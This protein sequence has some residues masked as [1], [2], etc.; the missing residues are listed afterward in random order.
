MRSRIA[1]I[2]LCV[3]FGVLSTDSLNGEVAG[4]EVSGGVVVCLGF[5]DGA[6]VAGLCSDDK[7]LVYGLHTEARRVAE[8]RSHIASRDL[9]GQVSAET[10]DG[11]NLPFGD[12]IVNLVIV[13]G[14]CAVSHEEL[15]RVLVAGGKVLCTGGSTSYTKPW[16]ADIDEWTHFLFDS[17]NNAVSRD[18]R[19]GKPRRVQWF[20]GPEHSRD[21]DALASMSAM[22]TSNGRVFYIYDEGPVSRIHQPPEWKLIARDAFN[23]KLLWKHDLPDWMTHLYFFRSGPLQL[24]RR[25]V[26]V[27]DE[28]FVTLGFETPVRKLDAATGATLLT[29][30]GSEETEELILHEDTLLVVKGDPGLL[31]EKSDDALGFFEIFENERGTVPK[32]IVAYHRES[33]KQLWTV[34]TDNLKSLVPLSLC[35]QGKKAFYL[36]DD[37]LHCLDLEKGTELWAS[38]FESKG[39]FIRAYAP[40]VVVHDDVIMCVSEP[41]IRTFS[42]EDG[43]TLWEHDKGSTGFGSPAD[44]FIHN[45]KAWTMAMQKGMCRKLGPL[46]PPKTVVA[47][48][49]HTGKI[50]KTLP[51]VVNQHHHRCYRN[52]ATETLIIIGYSGIQIFDYEKGTVDLNQW[53]RGICQYGFMPANGY[54]Y[55]PPDP[56]QCYGDVKVNGFFALSESNSLD[57]I[58]IKP[59]LE[60]G[61][62]YGQFQV[63]DFGVQA[64]GSWPTYRGNNTRTGGTDEELPEK[65]DRKWET[66]VGRTVT[67]PVIA[68]GKIYVADRDGYTVHCL[69]SGTGKKLWNFMANGPVDTPPTIVSGGPVHLCVFG[70][71]DGSVYC[72]N[73]KD[74]TLIWRFK[75]SGIERRIGS[76]DRLES[77]WRISGAV[78]VRDGNVYFAAGRSS[79]LDGGIKLYG[80]DLETGALRHFYNWESRQNDR[81]GALAGIFREKPGGISMRNASFDFGLSSVSGKTSGTGF[82]DASWFH[83]QRGATGAGQLNVQNSTGI[84]SALNPYTGLKRRRS[85]GSRARKDGKWNQI[86][87]LHQKYARYLEKEWF[88]AGTVLKG[89]GWSTEEDIQPR[90][91]LV[92]GDQ[93]YVA[94]WIDRVAIELKTGRPSQDAGPRRSVLRV[95]CTNDGSRTAEYKLESEPVWES[96]AAA[97]SRFFLSLK[98]GKLICMAAAE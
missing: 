91:M 21:H 50:E 81:Q 73:G 41:R 56:C 1:V 19:V 46:L 14:E 71:G 65:L 75:T 74:G 89:K 43:R 11:R 13:N 96:A 51:F 45:G 70:C 52:K 44:L 26:S 36:D 68:G 10:Y 33:G 40:T 39:L 54:I 8:A 69:D 57:D 66:N 58:E 95:Y 53:V 30:N 2:V 80:L 25:L 27:G 22:T 35:A 92:A 12:N 63:S 17:S 16:P 42:V 31:I 55:V 38:D 49:I 79:H 98:N 93:L 18:R 67:A 6:S 82:L 20:A 90:A 86:G 84:Y 88:P 94:G 83:R 59:V 29:Y 97:E 32:Q 77:P 85:E 72:L 78:L 5:K 48:D 3:L 60:K 7:L 9:Y 34:A 64:A 76:E 87:Y 23:G 24:T 61:N 28:V 47:F 62:G 4:P 37:K 15:D